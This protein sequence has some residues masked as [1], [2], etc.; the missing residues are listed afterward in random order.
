MRDTEGHAGAPERALLTPAL[1]GYCAVAAQPVHIGERV[2]IEYFISVHSQIVVVICMAKHLSCCTS[3][4]LAFALAF[5]TELREAYMLSGVSI[6]L[7]DA[8]LYRSGLDSYPYVHAAE[9]QIINWGAQD[10]HTELRGAILLE[11]SA[12]LR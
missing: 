11:D 12:S 3:S 6:A 5:K 10:I 8:E 1:L 9:S 2:L 7:C 4:T